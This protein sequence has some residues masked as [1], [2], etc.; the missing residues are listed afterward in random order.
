MEDDGWDAIFVDDDEYYVKSQDASAA[1]PVPAPSGG[2]EAGGAIGIGELGER[3]CAADMG[4]MFSPP[5]V[6][7]EARKHGLLAGDAMDLTTGWDFTKEVDRRKSEDYI[8]KEK[9]LVL[10]GSPPC[11]A[12]SQLQALIPDSE[13]KAK[14]LAEGIKH[15][16]F[17][18]LPYQKQVNEG[19]LLINEN[20]VGATSWTLPCVMRMAREA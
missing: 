6:G 1:R 9:P 15:M 19:S 14:Q 12:F 5:R 3:V 18:C 7:P 4:E 10:I 17:M 13:R 8:D 2:S 16:Q 11:T 20:P